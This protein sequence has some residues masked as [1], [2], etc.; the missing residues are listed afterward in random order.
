MAGARPRVLCHQFFW[1]PLFNSLSR[2]KSA[3]DLKPPFGEMRGMLRGVPL[4][5]ETGSGVGAQQLG[6]YFR[7]REAVEHFSRAVQ[8]DDVVD[9]HLLERRNRLAHVI[10]RIRGKV[11]AADD[12]MHLRNS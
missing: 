3:S 12:R 10:F 11:E 6:W 7:L 8:R 5:H 2:A 9:I 4:E 1:L